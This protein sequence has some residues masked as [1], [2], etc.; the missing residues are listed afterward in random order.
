M[1]AIGL[2][3]PLPVVLWRWERGVP[4][5][6]VRAR[7]ALRG[8]LDQ[9]GYGADVVD[10]VLLCASEL[11]ANAV[12]HAE[13]PYEMRLR[14]VGGVVV[15]EVDDRDPRIPQVA[16]CASSPLYAV[17]ERH[18]GGGLDALALVL[19]ERGRGLRIVDVLTNGAWGFRVS[20]TTKT[21]WL[22]CRASD[23]VAGLVACGSCCVKES[24]RSW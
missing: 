21:A 13:G 23:F 5:G 12:E 19:S 22:A 14:V 4:G 2:L 6:A 9:L 10:D 3:G 8:A 18:R 15:C 11:V 24:D 20:G 16:A 7:A 1:K 17:E